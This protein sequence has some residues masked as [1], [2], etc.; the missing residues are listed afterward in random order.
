MNEQVPSKERDAFEAWAKDRHWTVQRNPY[1]PDAY[2]SGETQ[3]GWWAW[4]A[5][6]SNEPCADA[7]K[8]LD[9]W[10]TDPNTDHDTKHVPAIVWK[11][12]WFAARAHEQSWREAYQRTV[13]GPTGVLAQLETERARRIAAEDACADFVRMQHDIASI[14]GV[15]AD[16]DSIDL[17]GRIYGA[18]SSS[19]PPSAD[20]ICGPWSQCDAACADRASPPEVTQCSTCLE[21]HELLTRALIAADNN[22]DGD[23]LDKVHDA[24]EVMERADVWQP[25]STAPRNGTRILLAA[26]VHA[27]NGK[28]RISSGY[29]STDPYIGGAN[30]EVIGAEEGFQGDGDQCI[31]SN[32]ECFTHWAPIPPL[33]STATKPPEQPA[34]LLAANCTDCRPLGHATLRPRCSDCPRMGEPD[35]T[36]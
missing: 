5:R 22:A 8:A 25:I 32:Q 7:D 28:P 4:Q 27:P 24:I 6:A 18:L 29:Y 2:Q 3:M 15:D 20:H 30:N 26:E 23:L 21:A 14:L 36:K 11:A 19:Q 13:A 10:W 31:P 34:K 16:T 1:N 9:R 17:H 12:A 33:S 35:V